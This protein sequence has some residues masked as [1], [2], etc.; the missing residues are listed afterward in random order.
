V[1]DNELTFPFPDRP[2]VGDSTSVEVWP[3][4]HWLS[5]PVEGAL[6]A[7]NI[8]ALADDDNWSVIDTGLRSV[9][10]AVAW[11]GIVAGL[12][13]GVAPS[14]LFATHFHPD[15]AGMAG[16][17]EETYGTKLHMSRAEFFT[18]RT[19]FEDAA[20][21]IP[22]AA[23]QLYRAAGWSEL[24]L[25]HFR[26]KFGS[27]GHLIYSPPATFEALGEGDRF[28]I[29]GLEWEAIVGKGHCAEH[30]LFYCDEARLLIS[31]DQVL[32][33]ISSNVSVHPQEP[34][35][36]P[37]S[38]WL[39]TL[40]ALKVRIANDVL[41]LPSHGAPFHG[42]HERIDSLIDEAQSGLDRVSK[43]LDQPKR[44]VDVF[45]LLFKRPI[46]TD[47]LR[48]ATGESLASL[49]WLER[50]GLVSRTLDHGGVAW[51]TATAQ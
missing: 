48:M 26:M 18:L 10:T 32:P 7:V 29:G 45:P 14:R 24:E 46:T 16:W 40:A 12:M 51:W 50:R 17:L 30:L 41:V 35:A 2:G 38:A 3:G 36:D 8:W 37:M 13:G 42:L 47:L 49:V 39:A 23:I 33:K 20:R 34:F 11:R 19:F 27:L 15:H 43:A 5:M 1:T 44:A 4:V 28:R 31:G 9:E 6:R 22:A 25:D 21:S